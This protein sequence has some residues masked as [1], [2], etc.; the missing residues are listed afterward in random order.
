M[1]SH[2]TAVWQI[3]QAQHTRAS[4]P[5]TMGERKTKNKE[6]K[7]TKKGLKRHKSKEASAPKTQ[8]E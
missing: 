8:H 2:A 1:Q 6:K 5:D 3:R 4:N 7:E